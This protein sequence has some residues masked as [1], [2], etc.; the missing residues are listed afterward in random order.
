MKVRIFLPT[1]SLEAIAKGQLEGIPLEVYAEGNYFFK[2]PGKDRLLLKEVEVDLPAREVAVAA[3][4]EIIQK[5][6]AGLNQ[7]LDQRLSELQ[8]ITWEAPK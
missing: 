1:G 5:T 2:E 7:W 3:A 8:A 4:V 6:R